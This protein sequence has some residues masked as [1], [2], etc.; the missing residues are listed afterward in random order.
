RKHGIA[1]GVAL[2][3]LAT[4]GAGL[5]RSFWQMFIPRSLVGVGEAA[6]ATMAPG[7]IA[8]F[9]E[10]QRRGRALAVFYAAI[11]A[12]SALGFVLGGRL[13][14]LYGW[15]AAFF[16]VG[17]PGLLFAALVLAIQEPRRGAADRDP[18]FPSGAVLTLRETYRMLWKTRVYGVVTVGFFLFLNTGPLNA[19]LLGCV[20]AN[21]RATAMAVNIFFIHALG[22]SISPPIIGILSD[23]FGLYRATLITPAMMLVSGAVLAY[24]IRVE[25]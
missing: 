3:S 14:E 15:R 25:K 19:V 12:G 1:A 16:A 13:S 7:I 20:P 22:D 2:W 5:A 21:I 6:Y 4:A 23:R 24:A 18:I 11:P 9:Y 17:L 8:D 10:E